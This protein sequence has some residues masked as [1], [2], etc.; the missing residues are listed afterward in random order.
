[1]KA[2]KRNLE[3]LTMKY[4]IFLKDQLKLNGNLV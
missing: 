1:M 3:K 4:L 2:S